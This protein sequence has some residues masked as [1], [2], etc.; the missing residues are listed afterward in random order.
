MVRTLADDCGLFFRD[1]LFPEPVANRCSRPVNSMLDC[2]QLTVFRKA[3]GPQRVFFLA[4]NSAGR[5]GRHRP[6]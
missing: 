4:A 2:G 5:S 6:C 1:G 3:T